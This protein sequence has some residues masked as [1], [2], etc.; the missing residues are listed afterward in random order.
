MIDIDLVKL[1]KLAF[2]VKELR[3]LTNSRKAKD[4]VIEF[5]S[6]IKP[7]VLI[8][9]IEQL[10]AAQHERDELKSENSSLRQCRAGL[11]RE[12]NKLEAEL[13]RRDAQEPYAYAYRYAGCETC[14]GFRDW[15]DELSKEYPPDW[16]LESGKITDLKLLYTAA[17]AVVPEKVVKL[18]EAYTVE[19]LH[20]EVHYGYNENGDNYDTDSIHESLTAAG[21]KYEVKK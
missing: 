2:N 19:S 10:E 12:A 4:S 14:E 9:M 7:D 6:E 11:S 5:E 17:P 21:V 1:K 8:A 16:M 13:K 15:R 18:P 3:G 20:G